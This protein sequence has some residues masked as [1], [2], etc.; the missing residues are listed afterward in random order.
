[1]RCHR[2]VT[3]QPPPGTY[4][5][6]VALCNDLHL[7]EKTAGLA[8]SLA[9]QGLPPG[10]TALV[11]PYDLDVR[12]SG[13]R[14]RGWAGYKVHI[15]GTCHEPDAAGRRAAPNLI[16]STLTTPAPALPVVPQ[17]P[18][19]P[20]PVIQAAAAEVVKLPVMERI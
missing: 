2:F 1:M 16:T 14:G 17:L 4:L 19:L 6:S 13:K 20:P 3:P 10:R 5:F 7:G 9:G 11:S 12:Y 8:T 18:V 15:S